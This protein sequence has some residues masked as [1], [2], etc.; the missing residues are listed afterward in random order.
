[1]PAASIPD[2]IARVEIPEE[3]TLSRV[4]FKN[5]RLRL[6]VFAFDTGQ[7]LTEHRSASAA[8]V[9]VPRGT[10]EFTVAGETHTLTPSSWLYM[11]PDEAHS[12]V[13]REP[14][15]LLLTLLRQ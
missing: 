8:V 15:V 1:M 9:Q 13:A 7:E 12:L 10:I 11:E 5:E 14:S 6:V 4:V 2:L 3:G